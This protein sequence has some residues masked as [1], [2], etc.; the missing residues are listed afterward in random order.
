MTSHAAEGGLVTS[1][2]VEG[3]LVT[4]HAACLDQGWTHLSGPQPDVLEAHSAQV[5]AAVRRL[6]ALNKTA[7]VVQA[8][9][10]VGP[11]SR[12]GVVVVVVVG[13]W[14]SEHLS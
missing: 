5:L 13:N 4:S 6:A 10:Q 11:R 9:S 7:V 12:D 1:H 2:A 8:G 14:E 3:G